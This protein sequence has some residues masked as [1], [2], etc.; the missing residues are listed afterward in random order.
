MYDGRT[1]TIDRLQQILGVPRWKVIRWASWLGLCRPMKRM[2]AWSDADDAYLERHLPTM[3]LDAIAQHLGRTKTAIRVRAKRMGVNK[4]NE[5][6]TMR[7]L[8]IA[9]GLDHRKIIKMVEQGWLKGSRRQSERT[10]GDMW[11][12]THTAIRRFVTEH[13]EEIDPRRM[14]WLWMVDLL[15]GGLGSLD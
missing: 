9:L 7:G 6:Y 3:S 4:T 8:E 12:F 1:A 13:P 10:A 15:A 11:I 2:P 5:G 14:D